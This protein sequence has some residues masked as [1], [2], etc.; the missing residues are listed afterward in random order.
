MNQ[1]EMKMLRMFECSCGEVIIKDKP[2]SKALCSKCRHY[3]KTYVD[4]EDREEYLDFKEILEDL[5]DLKDI[6]AFEKELEEREIEEQLED[7]EDTEELYPE[8]FLVSASRAATLPSPLFEPFAKEFYPRRVG[9]DFTPKKGNGFVLDFKGYGFVAD[10]DYFKLTYEEEIVK[11]AVTGKKLNVNTWH[12]LK[13]EQ[14]QGRGYLHLIEGEKYVSIMVPYIESFNEDIRRFKESR[15]IQNHRIFTDSQL[16]S[17]DK[18]ARRDIYAYVLP[19]NP[20]Q[21]GFFLNK[22]AKYLCAERRKPAQDEELEAIKSKSVNKSLADLEYEYEFRLERIWTIIQDLLEV[23]SMLHGMKLKHGMAW[24]ETEEY[25]RLEIETE[26]DAEKILEVESDFN[27]IFGDH[28]DLE[29]LKDLLNIRKNFVCLYGEDFETLQK[30]RDH[31]LTEGTSYTVYHGEIPSPWRM[32]DKEDAIEGLPVAMMIGGQKVKNYVSPLGREQ[33]RQLIPENEYRAMCAHIQEEERISIPS[34]PSVISQLL[35]LDEEDF[36]QNLQT[37]FLTKEAKE[38]RK[39]I[40]ALHTS[41]RMKEREALKAFDQKDDHGRLYNAAYALLIEENYN[42]SIVSIRE[43]LGELLREQSKYLFFKESENVH[44]KEMEETHSTDYEDHNLYSPQEIDDEEDNDSIGYE[45]PSTFD[46]LSRHDVSLLEESKNF[47]ACQN[48]KSKHIWINKMSIIENPFYDSRSKLMRKD[49]YFKGQN[50]FDD[51]FFK[52]KNV[53]V[54]SGQR[55]MTKVT[56][57][58]AP[59]IIKHMLKDCEYVVTGGNGETD[60]LFETIALKL[61][62]KIIQCTPRAIRLNSHQRKILDAGGTILSFKSLKEKYQ[63]AIDYQLRNELMAQIGSHAKE[64][65]GNASALMI[66]AGTYSGTA[67]TWYFCKEEG[68]SV[69]TFASPILETNFQPQKVKV[70]KRNVKEENELKEIRKRIQLNTRLY[71]EV[72]PF[73]FFTSRYDIGINGEKIHQAYVSRSEFEYQYIFDY[74][75]TYHAVK[76]AHSDRVDRFE[77]RQKALEA[78]KVRKVQWKINN[79]KHFLRTDPVRAEKILAKDPELR[80]RIEEE[81]FSNVNTNVDVDVDTS[82]DDVFDI[83]DNL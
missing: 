13:D 43:E 1:G 76:V 68:L 25:P 81:M 78:Q 51:G 28:T 69:E 14:D 4:F 61:G 20:V 64:Q 3:V 47:E 41:S 21:L 73:I 70:S 63:G 9:L 18:R 19:D 7:T 23:A 11:R 29:I 46:Q 82:V 59:T 53:L 16:E 44:M 77:E 75:A 34:S 79:V 39:K 71:F 48:K 12:I 27:K 52:E 10:F 54:G 35:H 31:L 5:Q 24:L 60:K 38:T 58:Y 83:I 42:P 6:E 49:I 62:V 65:G 74:K 72:M 57:A 36:L 2:Q 40:K 33:V 32:V 26:S 55:K 80:R 17:S 37:I 67:S 15:M 22:Y 30:R 56:K 66:G 45:V 8:E 50:V